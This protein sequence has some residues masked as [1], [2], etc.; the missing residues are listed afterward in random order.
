M[1]GTWTSM[2]NNGTI[3][4]DKGLNGRKRFA[5][6]K[7]D[8][9]DK[10]F[11]EIKKDKRNK[12]QISECWWPGL[13]R[14]QEVRQVLSEVNEHYNTNRHTSEQVTASENVSKQLM[15]HW[16]VWQHVSLHKCANNN[17]CAYE[18]AR[19]SKN[20]YENSSKWEHEWSNKGENFD[21][22]AITRQRMRIIRRMV[23]VFRLWC[24]VLTK[25]FMYY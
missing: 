3:E 16:G 11:C 23:K 9:E 13:G 25:K 10:I 20:A 4:F 21:M 22:K 19:V 7:V 5:S 14:K 1:N 12:D 8:G 2:T 17:Y 18:Q 24:H 15:A 6:C